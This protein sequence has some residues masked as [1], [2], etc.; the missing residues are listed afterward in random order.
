MDASIIAYS[1]QKS[2]FNR[3]EMVANNVANANTA[4]FKGDLAVYMK[5]GGK[6]NGKPIPVP[7]MDIATDLQQ[8]GLRATGRQLDVA[9]QGNGFFQVDT[10]LGARF[11]RSGTFFVNSEGA[12]VTAEGYA[13][14]GSGGPIS[15]Q[16]TDVQLKIGEDGTIVSITPEGDEPR[17]GIGVFKFADNSKLEKVGNTFFKTDETPETAEVRADFRIAQGMVEDSNVSSIAQMT[18]MIDVSRSVQSLAKIV[19]DQHN[20]IRSAVQRLTARS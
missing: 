7:D 1:A 3:L 16:S 17:G 13:V 2:L 12:L 19:N 5:T 8:G 18:E 6:I 20:L 11:T 9:I 14:I 15:L 4:G 10:P